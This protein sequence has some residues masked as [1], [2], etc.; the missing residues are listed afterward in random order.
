MND[1]TTIRSVLPR[2]F[3]DFS[4]KFPPI[5][6]RQGPFSPGIETSEGGKG[7]ETALSFGRQYKGR[8]FDWGFRSRWIRQIKGR[9]RSSFFDTWVS[10]KAEE[11]PK[12]KRFA[13]LTPSRF[14]TENFLIKMVRILRKISMNWSV[15]Y[16]SACLHDE[17]QPLIID[18]RRQHNVKISLFRRPSIINEKILSLLE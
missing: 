13:P 18:D 10:P 9:E 3:S 16:M 11:I 6:F 2:V 14:L 8:S 1:L 12:N 17:M 4:G 5:S 7:R 15:I